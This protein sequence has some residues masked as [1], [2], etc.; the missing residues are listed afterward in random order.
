MLQPTPAGREV[1]FVGMVLERWLDRGP[2]GPA[3]AR[4]RCRP[5]ALARCSAGWSRWWCTPSPPS[6]DTVDG[7]DG[8]DPGDRPGARRDRTSTRWRSA[9]CSRRAGDSAEDEQRFEA[10]RL[11]APGGRPARRRGPNGAAPPARRHG[12]DRRPRRQGRLPAQHCRCCELPRGLY[13]HLRPRGRARRGRRSAARSAVTARIERGRVVSVV[14]ASTTST[15][16]PGPPP[17]PADWLDMVIEPDTKAD[18]DGWRRA[19]RRGDAAAR[20]TSGCSENLRTRLIP[21]EC[22]LVP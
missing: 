17:P 11:A 22:L 8:G 14:P 7:S 3:D 1:P 21:S 2:D 10:D 18:R 20:C 5:G 13:R 9:G 15:P 6:P 16:T 12:A 19:T 4:P